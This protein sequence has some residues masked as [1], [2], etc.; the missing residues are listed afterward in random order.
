MH[1]AVKGLTERE[2]TPF[3]FT[4]HM[5]ICQQ[6]VTVMSL[7]KSKWKKTPMC[8]ILLDGTHIHNWLPSIKQ[9]TSVHGVKTHFHCNTFIFAYQEL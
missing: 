4:I 6:E 1:K 7:V 8:N 5:Q 3:T 2:R 9:R